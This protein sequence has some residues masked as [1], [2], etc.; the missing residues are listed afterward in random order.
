MG[1]FMGVASYRADPYS[2]FEGKPG[3]GGKGMYFRGYAK[4]VKLNGW[5]TGDGK[6]EV[7]ADDAE[8]MLSKKKH[9]ELVRKT[10]SGEAESC[11]TGRHG[12]GALERLPYYDP[13]R[14][15]AHPFGHC[16]FYGVCVFYCEGFSEAT[17]GEDEKQHPSA[18]MFTTKIVG[19][20]P[21]EGRAHS[22]TA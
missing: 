6:T 12:R 13:M 2:L 14:A 5:E 18:F 16:V 7:Y 4:A 19:A 11:A 20:H 22:T 3:P 15:I 1:S 10:K 21:I 9:Q 8:L 17:S